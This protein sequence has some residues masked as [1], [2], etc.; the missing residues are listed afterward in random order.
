MAHA[1]TDGPHFSQMVERALQD[2]RSGGEPSV[3]R[4]RPA[5]YG[6]Q[7]TAHVH[8]H[9]SDRGSQHL[10]NR[11]ELSYECRN[12]REILRGAVKNSLNAAAINVVRSGKDVMAEEE[13]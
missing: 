1:R 9:A 2:R 5:T 12:D 10:S 6:V 8:Q 3:P 11:Q 13:V 7:P 4:R